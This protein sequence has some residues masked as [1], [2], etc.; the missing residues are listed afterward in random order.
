M[1]FPFSWLNEFIELEKL[2]EK[3]NY[4]V[5]RIAEKLTKAG[6]EVE[7]IE[8]LKFYNGNVVVG[9]IKEISLHP[10]KPQLLVCEVN[11]GNSENRI[12]VTSDTSLEKEQK[13]VY[14]YP[15]TILTKDN[16]LVDVVN[17][18]NINSN[19]MLLSLEELGIEQKSDGV[20]R[21]NNDWAIG[22]DI[23]SNILPPFMREEYVFKVKVPSNRADLLSVLGIARELSAIYE[24]HLKPLPQY[25]FPEEALKPEIILQ[26]KRCLRYCSRIVKDVRVKDST[27]LIKI[28]L[29][30]SGLRPINNI[31]DTT[32]YIMLAIGQPMHAFDYNKLIGGKI[33]VRPSRKGEKILTLDGREITLSE[34]TMVIADKERPV[35][36]AGVIGGEETKVTEHT[37][38]IL[39]ES[40]YFDHNTIRK[41]TKETGIVTESSVRFARD[42]GFFTTDIAINMAVSIIGEGKISGL[43]DAKHNKGETLEEVTIKTSF[44]SIKDK[45]GHNIPNEK[46]KSILSSLGFVTQIKGDDI[47]LQVP[48]YRKDIS[49]EEDIVEEVARIYGYDNIPSTTPKIDKNPKIPQNVLKLEQLVRKNLV[50][51]GLTEVMNFSFIFEKEGKLFGFSEE[52]LVG[53]SNPMIAEDNTLRPILLINLLKT[54]KRNIH[55]GNKNL[56]LFEVGRVFQRE[57]EKFSEE[58]NLC[59]VLHGKIDNT[60]AGPRPLSYYDLKDIVDK[61]FLFLG[62]NYTVSPQKYPFLHDYISG[63]IEVEG[64][65]IGFIGKLHPELTVK[66]E[67][68]DTFA[69]ELSITRLEKHLKKNIQFREINKLPV[70]P[71]N[72][73]VL[74]PKTYYVHNLVKFVK[75]YKVTNP[76]LEIIEVRVADIYEGPNIPEGLKSVN[77]L[78]KFQWKEEVKE[79]T[80]IKV[81]FM[82]IIREIREKLGFS[83]RGVE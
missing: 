40:A 75:E 73:S 3:E 34:G 70:S 7:E 17:F 15:G 27:D 55:G 57:E 16:T 50:S 38:S 36:I 44:S 9:K 48:A 32:N 59:I 46:I 23:I 31:V 79:E 60:W 10:T 74:V 1:K 30:L 20:W 51:Q 4:N 62:I 68:E 2:L 52:T 83:V 47:N 43:V 21:L 56:F 81:T 8:T 82:D 72:I 65:R 33:I 22:S 64:E 80:E 54:V 41:T 78:I 45:I 67:I 19:G 25:K 26:D 11:V 12:V 28:R 63:T 53:I 6:I 58:K 61:L 49:I 71:K 24:L 29:L 35:A 77:L 14:C 76:N 18:E 37:T 69:C 42:I 66:L 13:V 39:L 5:H